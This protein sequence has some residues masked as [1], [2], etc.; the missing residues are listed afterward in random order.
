LRNRL[1]AIAIGL[2][3]AA[4]QA[5]GS[6]REA[7]ARE[8]LALSSVLG[9][10]RVGG[11]LSSMNADLIAREAHTLLQEIA[12]YEEPRLFLDDAPTLAEL[13]KNAT[14]TN[15]SYST[16]APLRKSRRQAP[17]LG[18]GHFKD[19]PAESK[20]QDA[21][22]DVLKAKG[23][24]YIKDVSTVLRDVSEKTVQ[25]ELQK[26]VLLGRVQKT[27]SRRWTSYSL[28]Q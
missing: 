28:T 1:D 8:L 25:R 5:P 23:N 16:N 24:V 27:G 11:L 19:I 7:L 13:S 9:I 4:I 12:D 2:I 21:I 14:N 3:D 17:D 10:A 20:R 22:F 6:A 26:M 18:K 15:A